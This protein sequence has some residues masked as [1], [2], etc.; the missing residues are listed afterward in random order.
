MTRWHNAYFA[1]PNVVVDTTTQT[2]HCLGC[3]AVVEID[4]IIADHVAHH[5]PVE[6]PP[7]EPVGQMVLW[8]PPSVPHTLSHGKDVSKQASDV[9]PP[10]NQGNRPRLSRPHLRLMR[11]LSRPRNSVS[12]GLTRLKMG[13]AQITPFTSPSR[14][15]DGTTVPS[16]RLF[17]THGAAKKTTAP[18]VA[19][20]SS[21]PT[22]TFCYRRP[23]A[24]TCCG[25][26]VPAEEFASSGSM[27][28]VSIRT[29]RQKEANKS[30]ICEASTS[31]APGSSY[32]LVLI[33]WH[34]QRLTPKP[35]CILP[36]TVSM[37]LTAS[38]VLALVSGRRP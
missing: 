32:T 10:P 9:T 35:E 12:P 1:T 28:F 17:P 19:P 29:T 22:G 20:S 14:C 18:H 24:G 30:Q 37:N 2:P 38:R 6:I 4:R 15:S 27:P 11:P 7:D 8:W 5:T 33:S 25:T 36:S 3:N 26:C 13:P 23:T 34:R 16:T 21:A 31:S